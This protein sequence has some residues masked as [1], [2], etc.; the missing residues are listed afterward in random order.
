MR[1]P[2]EAGRYE[3][4]VALGGSTIAIAVRSWEVQQFLPVVQ[5]LRTWVEVQQSISTREYLASTCRCLGFLQD[6]SCGGN[7]PCQESYR[8]P[9]GFLQDSYRIPIGFL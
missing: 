3:D 7:P 1:V 2:S 8:I 9:I 6:S 5:P 4:E